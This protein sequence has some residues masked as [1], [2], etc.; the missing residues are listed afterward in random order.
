MATKKPEDETL[1]GVPDFGSVDSTKVSSASLPAVQRQSSTSLRAVAPEVSQGVWRERAYVPRAVLTGDEVIS[2]LETGL[3]NVLSDANHTSVAFQ[4]LR[5]TWL[6]FLRQALEQTG[7]DGIDAWLLR[8]L[9]PPGRR[10]MDPLFDDL[11]GQLRRLRAARDLAQFEEEAL[12]CSEVV[13]K[14]FGREQPRRLSFKQ[15]ELEL[16]GKLEID[17][18]L[19]A[20]GCDDS[21]LTRMLV[22]IGKTMEQLRD[23]I[24]SLPGSKPAGMFGNFTRLKAQMRVLDGEIKRRGLKT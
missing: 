4:E 1:R 23:Q 5:A 13:R 9:R 12:K 7:G 11:L 22:E 6:P 18:L 3:R 14:A 16:E 17:D 10:A 21:E 2:G 24:R 20:A 19:L 15:M 8:V